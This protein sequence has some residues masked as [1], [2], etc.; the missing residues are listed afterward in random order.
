MIEMG[1]KRSRFSRIVKSEGD[2]VMVA[3]KKVQIGGG[4]SDVL[5]SRLHTADAPL[6]DVLHRGL[7]VVKGA[8]EVLAG[9]QEGVDR[10][11]RG[12][13]LLQLLEV[14]RPFDGRN[15]V[16]AQHRSFSS[17]RAPTCAALP[18]SLSFAIAAARIP[19]LALPDRF[20]DALVFDRQCTFVEVIDR[21][22]CNTRGS[23]TDRRGRGWKKPMRQV[24]MLL[25]AW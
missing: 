23:V 16:L 22:R 10:V 20:A 9:G 3:A 5:T 13:G 1:G 19:Q 2:V 15:K 17:T 14:V 8:S 12:E 18:S 21:L 11:E 7:E 4:T 24:S 6:R 25:H